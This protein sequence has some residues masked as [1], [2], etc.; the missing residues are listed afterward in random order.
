MSGHV[1][2]V[3]PGKLILSGEHAVVYG[4][5]ALVMAVDRCA[6]ARVEVGP[7][8]YRN[9]MRGNSI[10]TVSINNRKRSIVKSLNGD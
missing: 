3:S 4:K 5:P 9:E 7:S 10:K 8:T 1:E 6:R 2:A